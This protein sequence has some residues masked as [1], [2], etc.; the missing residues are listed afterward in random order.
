MSRPQGPCECPRGR[1]DVETKL[2]EANVGLAYVAALQHALQLGTIKE[3]T[4]VV[5]ATSVEVREAVDG[6][7]AKMERDQ[8]LPR[9]ITIIALALG[10]FGFVLVRRRAKI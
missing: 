1:D 9:W 4:D 6:A 3:K 10:A 2:A 7:I 5:E 8:V